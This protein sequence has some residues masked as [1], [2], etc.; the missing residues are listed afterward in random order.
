VWSG[1]KHRGS[2]AGGRADV[3]AWAFERPRG[4]RSF[5]FTGLDAHSAW[6]VDGVRQLIV[7]GI[8]WTAGR[9]IPATGAPCAIPA[10]ALDGYL[11]PRQP[12]GPIARLMRQARKLVH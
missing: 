8:L 6:S 3:V 7:N 9:A 10:G 5:C 2:S 12:R 4:G 11:T 1:R